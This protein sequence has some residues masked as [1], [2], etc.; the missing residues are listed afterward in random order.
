MIPEQLQQEVT[1][2]IKAGHLIEMIEE[3]NSSRVYIIFRNFKLPNSL[4]NILETDLLV[5]TT[6]Q[7][8]S[9]CFDMFW[10]NH[11]LTLINASIPQSAT[12]IETYLSV[13]WRRFSIHPYQ[14]KP[15]NPNVDSLS[16]YLTCIVQRLNLGI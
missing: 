15:W 6:M 4:Y 7:Y 9:S 3:E 12:S 2:L 14:A 8:P 13:Q 5:F 1:E 11:N 10:V 16:T